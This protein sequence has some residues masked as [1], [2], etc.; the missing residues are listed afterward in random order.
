MAQL[1]ETKQAGDVV[2]L[3][4]GLA[5]IT[6]DS[7]N[8]V[9]SWPDPLGDDDLSWLYWKGFHLRASEAA[10]EEALG[11]S[12]VR[13]D[14]DTKAMRKIRPNE[15]LLYVVQYSNVAGSPVVDF[16]VG[17]IRVLYGT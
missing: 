8:D 17:S 4:F 13:F 14:V 10:A 15:T 11:A 3:G 12:V 7:F 2:Y 6:T 9:S 5:I 16:D 1:D